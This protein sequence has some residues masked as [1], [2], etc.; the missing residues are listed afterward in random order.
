MQTDTRPRARP[1]TRRALVG[2]IAAVLV[3]ALAWWVLGAGVLLLSGAVLL[4]LGTGRCLPA[5][6]GAA[7][8]AAGVLL[9]FGAVLAGSVV[10]GFVSPHPHGRAVDLALLA[11][12]NLLGL[13]LVVLGGRRAPWDAPIGSRLLQTGVPVVAVLGVLLVALVV[14]RSGDQ[15]GL[16]WAMSG[17]ARNHVAIT[18]GIIAAGGLTVAE[19]TAT[20]AAVNALMAVLSGAGG[21]TGGVGEVIVQD[22]QAMAAT[23]VLAAAAIAVL[24][25]GAVLEVVPR[26]TGGRARTDRPVA[27]AALG[28]AAATASPLVLGYAARDGFVSAFATLP[29]VLAAVVLT[30]RLLGEPRSAAPVLLLLMV[31]AP[32][33]FVAWTVLAVVPIALLALAVAVTGA[34]LL[35]VRDGAP[36]VPRRTV[37]VSWVVVGLAVLELVALTVVV[38]VV[39]SKLVTQLAMPGGA[40]ET[41]SLLVLALGLA[42]VAV[43]VGASRPDVR[44]RALVPVLV[45]IVGLVIVDWL[46]DLP[47]GPDTWSYYALKTNWLISA[48]LVWVPFLPLALWAL[49][50]GAEDTEAARPRWRV[51]LG[52]VAGVSA[53]LVLVGSLT[54]APAPL[55]RAIRGWDQ[56]TSDAVVVALDAA[57]DGE[58]YVLWRWADP[59]NDRLGNFWAALA[60]GTDAAGHWTG[61]P[62]YPA[63][64]AQWAYESGSETVDL[65]DLGEASPGL[66]AYTRDEAL[67]ADVADACPDAGV[68]VVV[69]G[70]TR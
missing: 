19:M 43:G 32:L 40:Q 54:T 56:P 24:L 15:H 45:S 47:A 44:W 20:P 46:R 70:P 1:G 23:Y 16:A 8:W 21:R 55:L 34:R 2:A 11:V 38:Y 64:V 51:G 59:A 31:S 9:T 41:S 17:D 4:S 33:A 50:A 28:A 12:P 13:L 61:L 25:A 6:R 14:A 60:W 52:T 35:V 63:G 48:T 3:G 68:R 7:S 36:A 10:L 5:L 49:R 39:R 37:I 57:D 53:V 66:I 62:G 65:C 58:P 69:G 22:V 67:A 27:V 26:R 42:A 30:L 18:R 29:L